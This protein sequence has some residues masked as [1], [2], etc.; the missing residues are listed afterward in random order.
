MKVQRKYQVL[1]KGDVV[2]V[3]AP[4]YGIKPQEVERIKEYLKS[5]GLVPRVPKDLLAGDI[6][7]S[8]S[9]EVR[10]KHLKDALTNT[11]SKA[12]W[13][14]KGGS[15]SPE[16]IPL[17]AKIKKPKKQKLFIAFSDT[18]SIHFFLNQKWGWQTVHGP[19]L[20]QIAR[21]RVDKETIAQVENII[22]GR[23][24]KRD[25]KLT[26]VKNGVKHKNIKVDAVIGGNLKLVQCSIGT[27][28]QIEPK[29]KILLFEDINEKPYQLDRIL[30]HIIQAG[31]VKGAAAIVFG[32]FEGGEIE[33]D[34]PLI[35]KVLERFAKQ[36]KIPV[37]RTS[38]I[39]HTSRNWSVHFGVPGEIKGNKL[40][41][42]KV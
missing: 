12:V 26:Q 20:W 21:N 16:L 41:L 22:F 31:T 17:L 14:I 19:I 42:A 6:I 13:A 40:V 23:E 33:M 29:N 38:G 30:T 32:D 10:F 7:K 3:I 4:A 8:A 2:D 15:G 39:G 5:L 1:K 11:K 28:W 37:Y 24:Y 34:M 35:E 9:V 36:L 18:T 27:Q 25:F